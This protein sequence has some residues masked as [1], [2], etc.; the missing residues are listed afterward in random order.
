LAID[1]TIGETFR[2]TSNAIVT[3]VREE[4][5]FTDKWRMELLL[6]HIS[7]YA[8]C[9]NISFDCTTWARD[10]NIPKASGWYFIRTNTPLEILQRQT[11]WSPTYTRKRTGKVGQV[12]NYDIAGRA[13]RHAPDLAA[14]WNTED[15]YS[16]MAADLRA[17]AGDHTFADPG[18]AGLALCKYAELHSYEWQF[19]FITLTRFLLSVSCPDMVL[20]LGEQ[21]WRTKNGWPVLCMD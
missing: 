21:A 10:A 16:G 1:K 7:N 3:S 15:V 4:E 9:V 14:L 18:T 20:R 2:E 13:L 17:R 5:L 6:K 11:L 19:F 12:K 8:S